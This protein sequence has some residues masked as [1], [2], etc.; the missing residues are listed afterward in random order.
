MSSTS[1]ASLEHKTLQLKVKSLG[2]S[3]QCRIYCAVFGNVD[4]ANEVIAPNAFKNLDDFVRD[5]FMAVNHQWSNLPIATVDSAVQDSYG[6]LVSGTFHGTPEAQ[7]CRQV[8]KERLDRGKT[9]SASIGYSVTN[10]ARIVQGGT[11]CRLLKSIQLWEL[12]FVNVPCNPRAVA[13][14]VK[15]VKS[16]RAHPVAIGSAIRD[17]MSFE[18]CHTLGLASPY[19]IARAKIDYLVAIMN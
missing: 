1:V 15:S 2:D 18:Y 6:L 9:V 4:R 8:M 16:R 12:S 13:L 14:D 19:A 17:Y 3:G 7:A 11:P 5:G 10:D